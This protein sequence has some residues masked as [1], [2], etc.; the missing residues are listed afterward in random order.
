MFWM[1]MYSFK[2]DKEFNKWLKRHHAKKHSSVMNFAFPDDEHYI[3][4]YSII[5]VEFD[6]YTTQFLKVEWYYIGSDKPSVEYIEISDTVID[7]LKKL[8]LKYIKA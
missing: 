7:L 8:Q 2:T 1:K 6:N 3:I 4:Q 5:P